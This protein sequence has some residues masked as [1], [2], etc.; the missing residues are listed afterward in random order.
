MT[1]TL[2]NVDFT[3]EITSFMGNGPALPPTAIL[4]AFADRLRAAGK[5]WLK[6]TEARAL[7]H[8][9]NKTVHGGNYRINGS[10]EQATL[11]QVFSKMS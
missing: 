5:D 1:T 3:R 2:I 10:H 4:H 8:S 9:L 6:T 11:E 7:L